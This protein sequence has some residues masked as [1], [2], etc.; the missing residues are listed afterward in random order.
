M[1]RLTEDVAQDCGFDGPPFRWDE[2]RRFLI[3]AEL[4]AAMPDYEERRA[5]LEASVK[6]FLV[7]G[8]GNAGRV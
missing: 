4:D 5:A 8:I 3:R 7:F 6:T 1:Q 2:D